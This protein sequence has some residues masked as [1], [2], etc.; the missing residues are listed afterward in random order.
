L[1]ADTKLRGWH[2]KAILRQAVRD[3]I[4]QPILKRG[5]MGFP[6]P[7]D[8]WFKDRYK[9][10]VD[11]FVTG[12]RAAARGLLNPHYA[13]AIAAEHGAGVVPHGTR[14]W[15]LINLEIW[16]RIFI[17]GEDIDSIMNPLQVRRAA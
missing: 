17:D 6:V 16:Q 3:L 9:S 4:P 10:I 14:L 2:T 12:P 8:R 7:V 5:K 1:P 15:L 11:E 13:R